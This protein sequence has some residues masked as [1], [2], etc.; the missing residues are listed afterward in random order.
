M[1]Q[2]HSYCRLCPALC[3]IVVETDGE[4]V[5]DVSGN[6]AHPLSGGYTCPKGRSL[7]M[8]HHHP[9]RLDQPMLGRSSSRRTVSWADMDRDLADKV[10]GVVA[11]SGPD[12]V[13]M[14]VGTGSAFDGAGRSTTRRFM[15]ALGSRSYYTSGS[16]DAPCKP[17]VAEMVGG[18]AALL[19]HVSPKARLTL[20]VGINPV[21]SHGHLQAFPNPRRRLRDMTDRG[22]LWVVDPRETATAR[23]ATR[24][25]APRP[26]T[27]PVWLAAVVRELLA[28][29]D[30]DEL[31]TR[32]TGVDDLVA[33]VAHF[34]LD[35]ATAE[36][37]IPR[38]DLV[39]LVAAIRR[40]GRLGM[41]TG[42][43]MT[44]TAGAN[45]AQWLL[46]AI[47]VITDSL[48]HPEGMWFNP[49]FL[50]SFDR[51]NLV[52]TDG[53]GRPG[54]RSRPELPERFG[55]FPSAAL[56]DEIET[57]NLKALFVV[58]GNLATALPDAARTAAAL[59]TIEVLAV[60][61]VRA[62]ETTAYATHVLAVAGQLERADLPWLDTITPAI[63]AQYT[64]A[65]VPPAAGR[66]AVWR[67]LGR[68]ARTLGHDVLHGADPD[69]ATDDDI[70]A[71]MTRR[72]RADFDDLVTAGADGNVLLDPDVPWGW[73]RDGVVPP[74]GWRIAPAELV[75]QLATFRQGHDLVLGPSRQHRHLNSLFANEFVGD[76]RRDYPHVVISPQD[77]EQ[78]GIVSG[79]TVQLESSHGMVRGRARVDAS[80]RVGAV[81]LPHGYADTN[82]N[83]LTSAAEL[84]PLTGMPTYSGISVEVIPVG[85]AQ[86]A[87]APVEITTV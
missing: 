35:R 3:G 26:G 62:T 68:L 20:L 15:R 73:V 70:L 43:G 63:A 19:P 53:A 34:D 69:V 31:R 77:A 87:V 49:G 28:V 84:D 1:V 52:A 67:V 36:T 45:V 13:G 5:V 74:P 24:H 54:P 29:T 25:L 79:Q 82:V 39:D 85:V 21:V 32:A 71:L 14:Y 16:I 75:A 9:D 60:A 57:G 64:P 30:L 76:G 78:R 4:R 58:G 59:D 80:M 27:D 23:M 8:L 86:G 38:A 2:H 37:G 11:T 41:E 56:L 46:W 65:V 12:A 50:H 51:A 61:D 7:P 10:A 18:H 6:P 83:R 22:E 42:T 72:A 48:D 33:A 17:L 81:T 47:L 66:Q 55:E 40:A 44:M